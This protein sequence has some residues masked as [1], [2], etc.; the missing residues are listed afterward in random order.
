MQKIFSLFDIAVWRKYNFYRYEV[1]YLTVKTDRKR[2]NNSTVKLPKI[3]DAELDRLLDKFYNWVEKDLSPK[4]IANTGSISYKTQDR[5][6]A[7]NKRDINWLT[8]KSLADA[9]N[10]SLDSIFGFEKGLLRGLSKERYELALVI[11]SK[12][13]ELSD[14]ISQIHKEY[15]TIIFDDY[16]NCP[17]DMTVPGFARRVNMYRIEKNISLAALA[18]SIGIKDLSLVSFKRLNANGLRIKKL[19]A[20]S[21]ALN[22]SID[23]L[24]GRKVHGEEEDKLMDN[25]YLLCD[26]PLSSINRYS[27]EIMRLANKKQINFVD[28]LE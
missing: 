28:E 4:T 7:K 19:L 1:R 20:L 24:V 11:T 22:I 18:E 17:G 15:E 5:L 14:T 12:E 9:V 6:L 23:F 16:G 3:T 8:V 25:Y 10:V 26:L 27:E 2:I 21:L 13:A